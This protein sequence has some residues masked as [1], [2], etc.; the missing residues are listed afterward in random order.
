[1]TRPPS[2][3]ELEV[4]VAVAHA[5]SFS[6]AAELRGLSPSAISHSISSSEARLGVRLF[7]R[8]TRT[9]R[10]TEAGETLLAEL[11]PHFEGIGNALDGLQRF[12]ESP[13]GRVR[14]TVLRDAVRLLV[15]PKLPGFAARYPEIDVDISSDDRFVD[16]IADGYDA[17]IRYGGTVPADMVAARLTPDLRWVV[18]ASPDYLA[19]H[20]KPRVPRD[21]MHHRCIRIRTGTN[22]IY[23]WELGAGADYVSLDVPGHVTLD[24]SETAIRLAVSG[25]GLFYCLEKR[26]EAELAAGALQ[27]VLDRWAVKGPG[28]HAYYAS[29]RQVPTAL[30]AFIDYLKQS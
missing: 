1:M 29:H 10:L 27:V 6:R 14:V 16:L 22:R 21:L 19:A 20:G 2:L 11:V 15:A 30:R 3:P 13:R 28:F 5:G 23:H 25:G 24:D 7:H 12:R 26:V 17:G 18:V 8:T 9:L 4:F